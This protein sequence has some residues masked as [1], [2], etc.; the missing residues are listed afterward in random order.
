MLKRQRLNYQKMA[1]HVS[2]NNITPKQNYPDQRYHSIDGKGSK[3]T[4]AT[5][6]QYITIKSPFARRNMLKQ[7]HAYFSSTQSL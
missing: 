2:F 6:T 7:Q 1:E 4:E 5:T 3:N